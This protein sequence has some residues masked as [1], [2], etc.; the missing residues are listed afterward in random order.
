MCHLIWQWTTVYLHA[1]D[2]T[3]GLWIDLLEEVFLLVVFLKAGLPLVELQEPETWT[4]KEGGG[5]P[6]S[7]GRGCRGGHVQHSRIQQVSCGNHMTVMSNILV[8]NRSVVAI[9]WLSCPTYS[10][11]TGQLW[12][13]HDC[14]VQHTRLQQVS[15]GDHMTD[16]SNILVYNRSVVTITWLCVEGTNTKLAC[17]GWSWTQWDDSWSSFLL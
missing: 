15:C 12:W 13:S 2:L 16:M 4:A 7:R 11:T 6:P 10:S 3:A 9:T 5:E 17:T 14:H 1:S 8:Y